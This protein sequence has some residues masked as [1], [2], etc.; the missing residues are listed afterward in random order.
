MH[1]A[2]PP[3]LLSGSRTSFKPSTRR[4]FLPVANLN[5][6]PADL[7]T[8]A[9]RY[10]DLGIKASVISPRAVAEVQSIVNS[11]G[12][13]GYPTAVGIAARLAREEQRVVAKTADFTQYSERFTEHAATYTAQDQDAAKRFKSID[14]P[15]AARPINP[16]PHDPPTKDR[17]K[18][19]CWIGTADGPTAACPKGTTQYL[20][21]E[22]GTWKIRQSDES[23]FV[24]VLAPND[25]PHRRLLPEPPSSTDPFA[26]QPS[27]VNEIAWTDS[28]GT[29]HR[30]IRWDPR[31]AQGEPAGS[32]EIAPCPPGSNV[33]IW[34]PPNGA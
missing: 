30:I 13:M 19:T 16:A 17:P 15:D 3:L 23:K 28:N 26:G 1:G 12:V 24:S 9:A 8:V 31:P 21:V 4:G 29:L 10:A 34:D 32:M 14:F 27:G 5:V 25:Q 20:Y 33:P 22:D 11:H 18:E 6:D 2:S 7:R